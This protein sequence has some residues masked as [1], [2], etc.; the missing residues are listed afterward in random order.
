MLASDK[1]RVSSEGLG[2][3]AELIHSTLTVFLE[4]AA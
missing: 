3:V 2:K 1:G 4:E